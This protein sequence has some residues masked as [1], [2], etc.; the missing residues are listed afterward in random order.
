MWA[1]AELCPIWFPF[2]PLPPPTLPALSPNPCPAA[3]LTL[4]SA[5][6]SV[7]LFCYCVTSRPSIR[8]VKQ[9]LFKLLEFVV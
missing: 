4:L 3:S 2:L 9:L 5:P 7:P 6:P 8:V 1:D